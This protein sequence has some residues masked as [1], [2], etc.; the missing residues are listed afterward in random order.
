MNPDKYGDHEPKKR[1]QEDRD[2]RRQ[3]RRSYKASRKQ[4]GRL[5]KKLGGKRV[6][7]SGA[8]R[9]ETRPLR[10]GKARSGGQVARGDVTTEPLLVEAKSTSAKSMSVTMR[11]LEKIYREASAE[12]KTPGL[13]ISFERRSEWPGFPQDWTAVPTEWLRAV[14]EK[15]GLADPP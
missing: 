15:A 8:G 11:W 2:K 14:L 6:S 10:H 13:A 1:G 3:R 12:E 7:G 4:E 9:A 5:A